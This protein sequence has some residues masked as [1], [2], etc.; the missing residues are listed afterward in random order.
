MVDAGLRSVSVIGSSWDVRT[1]T[2]ED[3][4]TG[5]L[6]IC[7]PLSAGRPSGVRSRRPAELD[8]LHVSGVLVGA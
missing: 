4:Q 2:C 7:R 8:A 1:L 5:I 3:N 6:A